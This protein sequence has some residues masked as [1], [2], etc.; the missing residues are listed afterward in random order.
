MTSAHATDVTATP[1]RVPHICVA[2]QDRDT[3]AT[4]QANEQALQ[5]LH[6]PNNN[7]SLD[8]VVRHRQVSEV[9]CMQRQ[10]QPPTQKVQVNICE[11]QA[12]KLVSDGPD[13]TG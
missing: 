11:C 13:N 8:C 10:G 9:W 1:Q 7:I 2:R 12:S 6:G 3:D 4:R 5:A